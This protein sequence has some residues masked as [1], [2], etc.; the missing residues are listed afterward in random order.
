MGSASRRRV[1]TPVICRDQDCS[2]PIVF[3]TPPLPTQA[4]HPGEEDI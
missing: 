2:L 3:P 1:R 4:F